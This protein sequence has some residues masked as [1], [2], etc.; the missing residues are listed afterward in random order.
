[1]AP[2]PCGRRILFEA[3]GTSFAFIADV[4]ATLVTAAPSAEVSTG[5]Q[6]GSTVRISDAPPVFSGPRETAPEIWHIG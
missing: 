2:R 5:R 4:L 6:G 1:M 3:A